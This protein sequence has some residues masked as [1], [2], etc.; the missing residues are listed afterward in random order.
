MQQP[1]AHQFEDILQCALP[2]FEGLLPAPHDDIIMDLLFVLATWHGLAKLRMHTADTLSLLKI[3]TTNL[4]IMLRKF[5]RVT[6]EAYDTR[7][8]D[9]KS[10][11]D[12][13]KR[14]QLAEIKTQGIGE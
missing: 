4:G 5:K 7:E 8:L 9:K 12:L 1:T 6:C 3:T 14:T 10:F 11:G 13:K 2:A